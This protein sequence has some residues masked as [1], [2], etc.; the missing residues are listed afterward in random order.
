MPI[1]IDY[2][3]SKAELAEHEVRSIA[4]HINAALFPSYW[5][6]SGFDCTA[7]EINEATIRQLHKCEFIGAAKIMALMGGLGE[8]Y[9]YAG[10]ILGVRATRTIIAHARPLSGGNWVGHSEPAA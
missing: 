6:F 4:Y 10:T 2:G 5:D 7:G 3:S 1:G 9:N 8:G